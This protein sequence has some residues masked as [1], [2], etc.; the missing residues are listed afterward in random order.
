[1]TE[2]ELLDETVEYYETHKRG[3]SK[4]G[5]CVY[6]NDG[7]MCGVG[8]CLIDPK[9]FADVVG[10]VQYLE[11]HK[12]VALDDILQDKYKGFGIMFWH[13]I[14]EFHDAEFYWEPAGEGYILTNHGNVKLQD[15]KDKYSK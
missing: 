8:R 11:R 14:Q 15:I 4:N 3:I 9:S 1:M 6:Y 2:I 10:G 12:N 13:H 7:N 5:N